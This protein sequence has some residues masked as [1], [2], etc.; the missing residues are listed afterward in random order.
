MHSFHLSKPFKKNYISLALSSQ[1]K[2]Q[3]PPLFVHP[4]CSLAWFDRTDGSGERVLS[5]VNCLIRKLGKTFASERF[6]IKLLKNWIPSHRL[7]SILGASWCPQELQRLIGSWHSLKVISCCLENNWKQRMN[8]VIYLSQILFKYMLCCLWWPLNKSFQ[9][10]YVLAPSYIILWILD[11]CIQMHKNA[12]LCCQHVVYVESIFSDNKII[13]FE[14]DGLEFT[15][16]KRDES[17]G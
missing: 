1:Q 11:V 13:M 17:V 15:F 12:I 14:Q 5:S 7:L 10:F 9:P 16:L 8:P 4:G 6:G 2:N 3:R